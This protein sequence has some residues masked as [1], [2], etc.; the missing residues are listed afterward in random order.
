MHNQ[1]GCSLSPGSLATDIDQGVPPSLLPF[2][3]R[4]YGLTYMAPTALACAANVASSLIQPAFGHFAGPFAMPVLMAIG[5]LLAGARLA[6]MRGVPPLS[7]R[8]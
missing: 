5:V 2:R 4:E 1:R 6:Y 3:T 8:S 7:T